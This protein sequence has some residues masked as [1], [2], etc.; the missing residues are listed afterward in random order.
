MSV[1][2]E[3]VRYYVFGEIIFYR[4]IAGRVPTCARTKQLPDNIIVIIDAF[5]SSRSRRRTKKTHTRTQNSSYVLQSI[6]LSKFNT[7]KTYIVAPR[8]H[9]Y[10]ARGPA[11]AVPQAELFK[12]AA[13]QY[14]FVS[15]KAASRRSHCKNIWSISSSLSAASSAYIYL[16]VY[17]PDTIYIYV[18]IYTCICIYR[19]QF[20][21]TYIYYM[22]AKRVASVAFVSGPRQILSTVFRRPR[23]VGLN[24]KRG[25]CEERRVNRILFVFCFG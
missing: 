12:F 9:Y 17:I 19:V 7:K 22:Y 10:V 21:C 13:E 16:Y 3:I 5:C 23:S 8:V 14:D 4:N 24:E 18:Y 1:C 11:F 2:M 6:L 25:D 20:I 15:T